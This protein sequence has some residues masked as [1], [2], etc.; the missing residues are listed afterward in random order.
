M[1]IRKNGKVIRLTESDLMR[2]TRKVLREQ[3]EASNENESKRIKSCGPIITGLGEDTKKFIQDLV[4]GGMLVVNPKLSY[5]KLNSNGDIMGYVIT[6]FSPG[7]NFGVNKSNE[8]GV[9]GVGSMENIVSIFDNNKTSMK[10]L[11]I[12]L[13]DGKTAIK[14]F[15]GKRCFSIQ[16]GTEEGFTL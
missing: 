2:I 7:P 8:K 3:N 4:S 6:Y 12:N 5:R 16:V 11:G 15:N 14:N 1:R 13:S 10:K 9:K